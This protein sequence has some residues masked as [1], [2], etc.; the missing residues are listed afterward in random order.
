MQCNRCAIVRKNKQNVTL[1]P[2]T[3]K[4]FSKNVWAYYNEKKRDSLP[5]R[6]TKDPYRILISEYMLQQT[7]VDRVIPFY[8]TWLEVFPDIETLSQ[9][10]VQ[11]VLKHWQGLGYNRRALNL[12]K[13]AKIIKDYAGKIPQE[14]ADL[15]SLPGIGPY[16]AGAIRIFAWNKPDLILETNIRTAYIHHFFPK[17][18]EKID[19]TLL[20]PFVEKTLDQKNPREWYWA[21]MDYGSHL[22]K[23][24]GNA[25]K[26]SKSYTKQSIFKG[27]Q[28]ELRGK[29]LRLLIQ[30]PQT[31]KEITKHFSQEPRLENVLTQ[32]HKE[33]FLTYHKNLYAITQ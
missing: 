28:R 25:N 26:K 17:A 8:T 14:R 33:G 4:A 6:K 32:L 30:K 18:Q 21:L 12:H 15:E 9:S 22:K 31:K 2:M 23:E 1:L 7:Q 19:D 20:I 3:P 11:S 24:I 10:S 16:T 27:S 29:I 5:W 13:T